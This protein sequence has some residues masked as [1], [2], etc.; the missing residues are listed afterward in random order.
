VI[1]ENEFV[2]DVSVDK[3]ETGS[4]FLLLRRVDSNLRLIFSPKIPVFRQIEPVVIFE[5]W[6]VRVL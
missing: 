5:N 4:T 6:F 1:F 3:S 2:R